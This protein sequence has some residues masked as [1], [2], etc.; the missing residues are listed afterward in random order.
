[1]QNRSKQLSQLR[2]T[3]RQ[4]SQEGFPSLDPFVSNRPLIK[5]TIYTLRRK[6]SKPSCRCARGLLHESVV[7]TASIAGKTRLWTIPAERISDVRSGTRAYRA[8]RQARAALIRHCH[9]RQ[10]EIVRIIDQIEKLR[11]HQP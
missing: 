10:Q 9:Q 1:M 2:H 6:C 8:Y 5:G 4:L 11:T 7:L 3:L